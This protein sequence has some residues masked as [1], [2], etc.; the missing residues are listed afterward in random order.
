MACTSWALGA[1]IK[2]LWAKEWRIG[3]HNLQ[4]AFEELI[5]YAQTLQRGDFLPAVF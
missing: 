1:Q 5:K 3:S 2:F 4:Q